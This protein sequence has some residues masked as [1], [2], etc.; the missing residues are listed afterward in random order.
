MRDDLEKMQ[1]ILNNCVSFLK[2]AATPESQNEAL[3]AIFQNLGV[4]NLSW[5]DSVNKT[6]N[7][8]KELCMFH[9]FPENPYADDTLN[10]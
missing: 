2:M 9:G 7:T 4:L 8:R 1:R 10:E 3:L 6:V 5:M